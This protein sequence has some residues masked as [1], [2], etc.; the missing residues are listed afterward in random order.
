MWKSVIGRSPCKILTETENRPKMESFSE[1]LQSEILSGSQNLKTW[2]KHIRARGGL[3]VLFELETWLKG[4]SSFMNL[5]H[6]PLSDRERAQRISRNFAPEIQVVRCAIQICENCAAEIIKMGSAEEFEF[7]SFIA[8]QMRKESLSRHPATWGI[9][10][11]SPVESIAKLLDGL[12][13]LRVLADN[14]SENER[15]N[16]QVYLSLQRSYRRV[17]RDCCFLSMLMGQ[18]FRLEYDLIE[19][20]A[21]A[22]ALRSIPEKGLR[23]KAAR[24]LLHFY[25]C[26]K[27][28]NLVSRE[29]NRDRPLRQNLIIFALIHEEMGNIADYMKSCFLKTGDCGAELSS[30]A[31]LIVCS[32]AMEAQHIL[33]RDLVFVSRDPDASS[34]FSRVESSHGLLRN[35][36]EN[37]IIALVQALDGNISARAIF[38]QRANGFQIAERLRRDLWDLRQHL[39]H[40]LETQ[41]ALDSSKIIE[42]L[43]LLRDTSMSDLK[44]GDCVELERFADALMTSSSPFE[45]RNNLKKFVSYLEALAQEVSKRSI[46]R[47][48]ANSELTKS[49]QF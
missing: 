29:L 6:L 12:N 24:A 25:R 46:L 26:L 32:L 4:L 3:E 22:A 23:R 2:I 37:C 44:H 11:P 20:P 21:L 42:R 41:E 40:L 17:L 7:E 39:K 19:N 15:L 28:L 45:V 38:P 1:A 35:C 27:Y 30:A 8:S 48:D 13:D 9:D 43:A 31:E 10:E 14:R 18:K 5:R 49:M 33:G 34:V 16:F 36:F 47:G